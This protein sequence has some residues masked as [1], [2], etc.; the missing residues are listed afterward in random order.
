M[1]AALLAP[2]LSATQAPAD[3]VLRHVSDVQP[4]HASWVSRIRGLF[5][6]RSTVQ[7]SRPASAL[8]TR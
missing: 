8:V 7:P 5:N 3:E 1:S 6:N 4:V 2:W